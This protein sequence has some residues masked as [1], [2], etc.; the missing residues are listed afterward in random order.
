M[1]VGP[2]SHLRKQ[3]NEQKARMAKIDVLIMMG[4]DSDAPVMTA[5]RDA[6]AELGLSPR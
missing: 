6:L 1:G 4:S 2:H 3:I 5:A